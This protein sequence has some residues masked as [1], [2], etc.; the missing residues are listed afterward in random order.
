M[1]KKFDAQKSTL[2]RLVVLRRNSEAEKQR[3]EMRKG[4]LTRQ[5]EQLKYLEAKD[6]DLY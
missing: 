2:A 3:L 1:L 4:N 6:T 5:L